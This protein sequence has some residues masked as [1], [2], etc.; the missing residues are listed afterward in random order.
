MINGSPR[1]ELRAMN[2][3]GLDNLTGDELACTT[4]HDAPHRKIIRVEPRTAISVGTA[5]DMTL[6][7]E[8]QANTS[9]PNTFDAINLMW[10]RHQVGSMKYRASTPWRPRQVQL[11][12]IGLRTTPL[13]PDGLAPRGGN[14]GLWE[15]SFELERPEPLAYLLQ[16]P[17]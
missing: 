11:H 13:F 5:V 7:F 2:L 4:V 14:D 16:F 8:W 6:S 1:M 9:E 17:A 10:F 3:R 12:S 15:F